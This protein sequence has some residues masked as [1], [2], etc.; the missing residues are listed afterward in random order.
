MIW[1]EKL[2][3]VDTFESFYKN[4]IDKKGVIIFPYINAGISYH[5][6]NPTKEHLVVDR[7]YIVCIN[8]CVK[9]V[10]GLEV[11]ACRHLNLDNPI[12]LLLSGV[13]LETDRHTEL[14]I[15]C[16]EAYWETLPDSQIRKEYWIPAQTPNSPPNMDINI[17]NDF[18]GHKYL[19]DDIKRLINDI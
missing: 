14:T 16:K 10:N 4:V 15:L 9:K 6:M 1:K 17:V 5:P 12:V 7:S 2:D 8:A 18:F 3:E 19:P 13:N 11:D